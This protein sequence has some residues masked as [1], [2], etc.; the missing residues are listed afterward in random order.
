[1]S[2]DLLRARATHAGPFWPGGLTVIL[3]FL[4]LSAADKATRA[5]ETQPV[6]VPAKLNCGSHSS[7]PN[8][9][10]SFQTDL[11]FSVVDTLWYLDRKTENG[12]EEKFRGIRSPMGA[13]LVVGQGKSVDGQTWTYEFSGQRNPRGVTV[14][15]GSLESEMPKGRRS[16]S[17]AIQG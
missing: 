8:R 2:W 4:V 11:H 16:C 17:L 6:K 3:A 12:D 9:L 14:L 1:M 5:Q 13:M 15:Q 10:K 7:D